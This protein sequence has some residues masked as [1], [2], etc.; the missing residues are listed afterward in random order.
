MKAAQ[1]LIRVDPSIFSG[2]C[3]EAHVAPGWFRLE[4]HWNIDCVNEFARP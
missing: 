1:F 4:P 3:I 2:A